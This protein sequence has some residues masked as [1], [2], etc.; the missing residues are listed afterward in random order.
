MGFSQIDTSQNKH[1]QQVRISKG[2][3]G[4]SLEVPTVV[5]VDHMED[6][7]AK[8]FGGMRKI[9]KNTTNCFRLVRV[10]KHQEAW[11][12]VLER[13]KPSIRWFTHIGILRMNVRNHELIIQFIIADEEILFIL[14][15]KKALSTKK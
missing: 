6:L 7:L 3:D 12:A 14:A 5:A 2:H 1:P 15:S 9:D 4:F 13:L 10:D 8:R 11:Q